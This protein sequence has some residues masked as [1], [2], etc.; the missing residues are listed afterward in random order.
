MNDGLVR[1]DDKATVLA[2]VKASFGASDDFHDIFFVGI[3]ALHIV[4]IAFLIDQSD[5]LGLPRLIE[6]EIID[7]KFQVDR[8]MGP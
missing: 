8:L 3:H 2:R 5:L 4:I 7:L 1:S 6:S